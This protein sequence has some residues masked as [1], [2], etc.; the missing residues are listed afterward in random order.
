MTTR[1]PI[2]CSSIDATPQHPDKRQ[3]LMATGL[4]GGAAGKP[5]AITHARI[6]PRIARYCLIT[7]YLL[8]ESRE[9]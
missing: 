3:W 8:E 2:A 1:L 4:A 7:A 9:T 5:T 6:S